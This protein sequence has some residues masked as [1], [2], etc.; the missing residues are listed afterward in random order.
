M[1]P[2]NQTVRVVEVNLVTMTQKTLDLNL[3]Y[4]PF[5]RIEHF[6]ENTIAVADSAT[7]DQNS[8]IHCVLS[9]IFPADRL[10]WE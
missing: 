4:Q 3:K 7:G 10:I 9:L 6:L 5:V 1:D 2:V 8:V